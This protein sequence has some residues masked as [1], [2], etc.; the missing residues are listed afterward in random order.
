MAH[1]LVHH[2]TLGLRDFY[3]TCIESNREEEEEVPLLLREL[4]R[5]AMHQKG[6]SIRDSEGET[7]KGQYW[8]EQAGV[9]VLFI[10][11]NHG[12]A[13]SFAPPRAPKPHKALRGGIQKSILQDFSA[14]VGTSCQKLTNGQTAP[15]TGTGYPHEGPFVGRQILYEK[16]SV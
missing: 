6:K 9:C 10:T 1:R 13:A 2:S 14:K 5:A 16:G 4:C 15:R 12:T 7:R 3:R 11:Q 8:H